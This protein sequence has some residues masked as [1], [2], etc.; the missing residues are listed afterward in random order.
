MW[1]RNYEKT[2]GNG[3]FCDIMLSGG[4]STRGMFQKESN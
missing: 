2:E 4:E 1:T 3:S